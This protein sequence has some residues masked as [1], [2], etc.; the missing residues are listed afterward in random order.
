VTRAG[1][2]AVRGD[3]DDA[4]ALAAGMAGCDVVF[5]SAAKVEVWGR[6]K[7]FQRIN[8]DGTQRVADAARAAGVKR[9]IHVSTEAVLVGKGAP[10]IVKADETWPL[11][12]RPLGN[13]PWSKGRAEEVVRAANRD[14]L[15]TVIVRP[16]FIW[17]KGDTTL[18]PKFAEA[19]EQK[20][21]AWIGGGTFAVAWWMAPDEI[22]SESCEECACTC[23]GAEATLAETSAP[24]FDEKIAPSAAV[25]VAMPTWRKVELIPEAIPY[26]W[27][28]STW[29]ITEGSF[30]RAMTFFCSAGFRTPATTSQTFPLAAQ[31]ACSAKSRS[32][33]AAYFPI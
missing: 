21:F 19:V 17:G 12:R 29:P 25:P 14:G 30:A 4:A 20:R 16:R 9:L 10:K 32:D 33:T 2:T 24:I 22:A 6:R 28:A 15:T 1:A 11:P 5:H 13:Y 7:D 8:I 26:R 23:G 31:F 27:S 18:L 3:L